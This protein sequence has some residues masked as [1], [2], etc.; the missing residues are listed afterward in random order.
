[1]RPPVV[2]EDAS[3]YEGEWSLEDFKWGIGL[4]HYKSSW[5]E[6][7]GYFVDQKIAYGRIFDLVERK[8][9]T[10]KF[11]EGCCIKG[12]LLTNDT[13][14]TGSF[15]NEGNADGKCIRRKYRGN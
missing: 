5:K 13:R 4:G 8:I 11:E 6:E 9:L 15:D 14:I 12:E 2:L 3:I 7:K 1:M 10:G